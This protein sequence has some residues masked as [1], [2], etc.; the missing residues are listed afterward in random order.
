MTDIITFGCRLNFYES[1]VIK[2]A[3][4]DVDNSDLTIIHS[5]SVTNEAERKVRK[6][7]R[8]AYR[9]DNDKRIIVVGC[10]AELHKKE[11]E[12][13]PEVSKVLGNKEKLDYRNYLVEFLKTDLAVKDISFV[14]SFQER[15]RAFVQIQ[16]GCNHSCTFCCITHARGPNK[17]V[18]IVDIINQVRVLVQNGHK[19]IVLTGV[20]IT[21]F[22]KDLYGEP[23]L[24]SMIKRLLNMVPALRRLRLSSVDVAEIDDDLLYLI[25][26]EKRLMPHIHISAQS[27]DDMILKRMKRRH[28]RQQVIDFCTA[29]RSSRPEVVFGADMIVGFPTETEEMFEHS[30]QMIKAANITYLHVFQYSSRKGTPA[31]RM[32]QVKTDVRK[33]RAKLLRDLGE[34]Q[35]QMFY[36]AQ[37]GTNH[38]VIMEKAE[39]GRAQN[40]ALVKLT[41]CQKINEVVEVTIIENQGSKCLIGVPI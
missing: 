22:G 13:M 24:A 1:S 32:P 21:D 35:L 26:S 10:A 12:N 15:A 25:M 14:P 16:N 36:K 6:A 8:K 23:S 31:A 4:K 11:Y 37:I 2:N 27:G 30:C 38:E 7:I 3:L 40:F 28:N 17:S 18:E 34:E 29:V 19:E 9:E 5:C 20:D 33:S 39:Y 41:D